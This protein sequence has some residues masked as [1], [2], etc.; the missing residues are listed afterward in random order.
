MVST[1]RVRLDEVRLGPIADRSVPAVVNGGEMDGSLLGMSYLDRFAEVRI[2]DGE[3][4]L[5]R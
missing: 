2:S 5:Q 3:L 4:V 1:A